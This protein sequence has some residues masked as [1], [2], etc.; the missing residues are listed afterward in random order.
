MEIAGF[1][2]EIKNLSEGG[3]IVGLVAAFN[4]V[5]HGGDVIVPGAFVASLAEHKAAGTAPAMLLHHDMSRP[6]GRW[7]ELSETGDGLLAKGKITRDCSDGAEAYALARD[8]ALTGL[9]VGYGV[10]KAG[11]SNGARLLQELALHEASL[12]AVPMNAKA[13]VVSVKTIDS[14]RDLE[15]LL[16]AGLSSRKA[17]AAANAAWPAI[18]ENEPENEAELKAIL[19]ASIERITK[20]GI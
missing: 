3:E 12:V 17:R 16:R 8:G 1:P 4:N 10:K 2:L 6:I 9:S 7:T 19:T 11:R 5:D 18:N 13:R 14:I 15:E 20:I